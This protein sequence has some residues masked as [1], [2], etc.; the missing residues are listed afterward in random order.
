MFELKELD[1]GYKVMDVCRLF[2]RTGMFETKASRAMQH[3]TI[4]R[5]D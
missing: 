1:V 4:A 2:S 5:P 3:G